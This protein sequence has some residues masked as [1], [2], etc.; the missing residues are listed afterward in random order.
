MKDNSLIVVFGE[1][2]FGFSSNVAS[3]LHPNEDCTVVATCHFAPSESAVFNEFCTTFRRNQKSLSAQGTTLIYGV[4]MMEL[5]PKLIEIIKAHAGRPI[6][7]YFP[8]IRVEYENTINCFCVAITK[9]LNLFPN[10]DFE[11]WSQM[12]FTIL[13][14]DSQA[15]S[16]NLKKRIQKAMTSFGDEETNLLCDLNFQDDYKVYIHWDFPN[17][18]PYNEHC[19]QWYDAELLGLAGFYRF[20][21]LNINEFLDLD[22]NGIPSLMDNE[23]TEENK[24]L[25]END[26]ND[27]CEEKDEIDI[28]D[29]QV[30]IDISD[31][32]VERNIS[33]EK[34]ESDISDEKVENDISDEKVEIEVFNENF[35]YGSLDEENE[36]TKRVEENNEASEFIQKIE[37]EDIDDM[38]E[39]IEKHIQILLNEVELESLQ[40][41]R[42]ISDSDTSYGE[43]YNDTVSESEHYFVHN[44]I[45]ERRSPIHLPIEE[46]SRYDSEERSEIPYDIDDRNEFDETRRDRRF[47]KVIQNNVSREDTKRLKRYSYDSDDRKSDYEPQERYRDDTYE[48]QEFRDYERETHDNYDE[49][50]EYSFAGIP[51]YD[52]RPPCEIKL[53][54]HIFQFS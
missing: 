45:S 21:Y 44:R 14:L 34:A 8:F 41:I 1:S 52:F 53:D 3:V 27:I 30:E 2:D 31:K 25:N 39:L 40:D 17:Y 10:D 7:F 16:N 4:D 9:I 26:D 11:V 37:K 13:A 38:E 15:S 5:P 18:V 19:R 33:D 42:E 28:S 23:I 50:D 22:E 51:A 29:L 47:L 6:H 46:Y 24:T 32:K 20:H 54:D 36:E 49:R 35:E 43:G 12:T 48:K